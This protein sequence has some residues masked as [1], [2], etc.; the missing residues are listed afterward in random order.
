M[1]IFQTYSRKANRLVP[2]LLP[3]AL[4]SGHALAEVF[5]LQ[6]Q[7]RCMSNASADRPEP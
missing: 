4:M 1:T 6:P 5:S 7:V 3:L 2:L